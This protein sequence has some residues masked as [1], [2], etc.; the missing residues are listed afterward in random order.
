MDKVLFSIIISTLFANNI[1]FQ[2]SNN[3]GIDKFLEESKKVID[4]SKENKVMINKAILSDC[5]EYL[6]K[7]PKVECAPYP[8]YNE[9]IMKALDLLEPDYEYIANQRAIANMP[10]NKMSI[11]N[12]KTMLTFI[13]RGERFCDGHIASFVENGYL[14]ELLLRLSEL[15]K[16]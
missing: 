14:L 5:I 9:K 11:D 3:S 1:N 6:Q 10:V 7:K 16:E 4:M 2:I 12:I 13:N 15:T 8:I